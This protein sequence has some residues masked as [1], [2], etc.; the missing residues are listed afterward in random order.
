MNF[1]HNVLTLKLFLGDLSAW[2]LK[3]AKNRNTQHL[4]ESM[5]GINLMV[6]D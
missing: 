4:L 2:L 5:P 6:S 1:C 3:N